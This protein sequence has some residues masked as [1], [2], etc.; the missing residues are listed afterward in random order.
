MVDAQQADVVEAVGHENV[1]GAVSGPMSG[2][3]ELEP[4]SAP[5]GKLKHIATTG[6]KPTLTGGKRF[7][8]VVG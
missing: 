5:N 8:D 1:R 4:V 6:E 3:S 7:G 2:R